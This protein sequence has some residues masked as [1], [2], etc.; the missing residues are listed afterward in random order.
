MSFA[1]FAFILVSASNSVAAIDNVGKSDVLAYDSNNQ[2]MGTE[3]AA[4]IVAAARLVTRAGKAVYRAGSYAA[5]FVVGFVQGVVT[6]ANGNSPADEIQKLMPDF[7]Y[8]RDD[9][10]TFDQ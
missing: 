8:D 9:L 5:G 1:A 3:E 2:D 4:R 10:T 7:S 6:G